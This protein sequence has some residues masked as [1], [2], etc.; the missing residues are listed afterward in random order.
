MRRLPHR[1][2]SRKRRCE[3]TSPA[4]STKIGVEHRYQ[5]IVRARDAGLGMTR[6][7]ADAH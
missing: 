1:S 2:G 5:A 6:K 3:I 7:R 4:S